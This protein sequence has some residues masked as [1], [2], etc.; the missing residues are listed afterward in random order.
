MLEAGLR[1][2][3][4]LEVEMPERGWR[5]EGLSHQLKATNLMSDAIASKK[6]SK[7]GR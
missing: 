4:L 1:S 3:G 2:F 5:A 6:S 7:I